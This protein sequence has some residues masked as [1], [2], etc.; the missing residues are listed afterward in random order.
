[1]IIKYFDIYESELDSIELNPGA[2][3]FCSDTKNIYYDRPDTND[4]VR[5]GDVIIIDTDEERVNLLTP[6]PFKIYYVK[7]VNKF[8]ISDGINWNS[9]GSSDF[10]INVNE[11]GTSLSATSQ[12]ESILSAYNNGMSIRVSYDGLNLYLNEFVDNS[13]IFTTT[14]STDSKYI[15]MTKIIIDSN[16]TVTLEQVSGD[17]DNGTTSTVIDDVLYVRSTEYTA[18]I[19]DGMLVLR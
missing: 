18:S 6:V 8:Y 3:Y 9:I 15:L 4:R 13:F 12:Y 2:I 7:D 5:M 16:D 11:T 19:E 1:M 10:V 17:S 14:S